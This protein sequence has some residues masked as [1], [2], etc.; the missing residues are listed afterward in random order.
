MTQNLSDDQHI[1]CF[2]SVH[3]TWVPNYIGTDLIQYWTKSGTNLIQ[4]QTKFGTNLIQFHT[5][6]GTKLFQDQT[7]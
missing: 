5:K 2:T 3:K 1:V 4:Y 7:F 6:F